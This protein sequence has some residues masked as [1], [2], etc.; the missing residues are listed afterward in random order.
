[1]CQ[2][3]SIGSGRNAVYSIHSEGTGSE[4]RGYLL[5]MAEWFDL[6]HGVLQWWEG[7]AGLA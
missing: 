6:V 7:G 3:S 2:V 4:K 1:M 5:G